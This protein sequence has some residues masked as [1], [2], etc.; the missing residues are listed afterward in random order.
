MTCVAPP[1]TASSPTTMNSGPGRA[2]E[3]CASC[4]KDHK[5]CK[6]DE[7]STQ[8]L[9]CE[10]RRT[11]CSLFPTVQASATNF[12]IDPH[13]WTLPFP[14]G[15]SQSGALVAA[16]HTPGSWNATSYNS[17]ASPS[18]Q[19]HYPTQELFCWPSNVPLEGL[20]IGQYPVQPYFQPSNSQYASDQPTMNF[21][22]G[23]KEASESQNS[24]CNVFNRLAGDLQ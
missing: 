4:H 7:H 8:C 1:T 17:A 23:S 21:D 20:V 18:F 12:T 5:K 10:K 14:A 22:H 3:A 24:Q 13:G 15:N 2:K 6:Y 9:R 16:E 19:G 11:L